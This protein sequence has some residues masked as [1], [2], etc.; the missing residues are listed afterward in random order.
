MSYPFLSHSREIGVSQQPQSVSIQV[1]RLIRLVRPVSHVSSTGS[2]Q[3]R[4]VRAP[5]GE[6]HLALFFLPPPVVTI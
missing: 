5:N 3:H 2:H 1:D 6:V 4:R